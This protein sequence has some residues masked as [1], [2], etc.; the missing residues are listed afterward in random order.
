MAATWTIALLS[1]E[2]LADGLDAFDDPDP[3][4]ELSSMGPG[5]V[6]SQSASE[7][8]TTSPVWNEVLG[9]DVVLT[10]PFVLEMWDEDALSPSVPR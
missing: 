1:G 2:I 10:N 3:Y 5:L 7:S 9:T 6:F 8:N 4:L